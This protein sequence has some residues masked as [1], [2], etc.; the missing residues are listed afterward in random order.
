[1]TVRFTPRP[2]ACTRTIGSRESRAHWACTRA[3][4]VSVN[5]ELEPELQN[6]STKISYDPQATAVQ[7]NS[8]TKLTESGPPA[9]G[10]PGTVPNE[11]KGNQ[12][13]ELYAGNTPETTTEENREQQY[14]LAGHEQTLTRK[15]PLVPTKVYASVGIPESYF[16]KVWQE[17]EKANGKAKGA[18]ADPTPDQ[19]KTIQLEI[20][21]NIEDTLATLLGVAEPGV[22]VYPQINVF[23]FSDLPMELPAEPSFAETSLVWLGQNWRTLALLGVGVFSMLFLRGMIRSTATETSAESTVLDVPEPQLDAEEEEK[24]DIISM[25]PR[26][27]PSAGLTLRQE[28]SALVKD[29]PDA[30][31]NV[32]R[33]WIGDAA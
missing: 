33:T 20:T 2:N 19:T 11:V 10:R 15:A 22:D 4:A 12:P 28:L 18:P 14:S 23:S 17:K 25:L 31:A 7:S 21:K 24:E 13:R 1:M 16:T 3:S 6:D 30:A 9:A 26:R 8:V 32:L 5:V 27:E 29:D